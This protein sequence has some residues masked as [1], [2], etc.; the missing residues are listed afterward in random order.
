LSGESLMPRTIIPALLAAAAI[1]SAAAPSFAGE[2][3]AFSLYP[4][5]DAE[6]VAAGAS[7]LGVGKY[8]VSE[9]RAHDPLTLSRNDVPG[10][11]RI[12]LDLHSRRAGSMSDYTVRSCGFL[13][14]LVAGSPLLARD[15]DAFSEA[16]VNFAMY[17]ETMLLEQGMTELAKGVFRRSRPYAY[18]SSLSTETR[19]ERNAALSFWSGHTASAFACAMFAGYVYQER[20]P[21]SEYR[22]PIWIGGMSVAA[23]TAVLRVR[24]GQHFPTDVIAGAAAGSFAGWVVPCLHRARLSGVAVVTVVCGEPGL[25][26]HVAF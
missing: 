23:L 2:R 15:D 10:F 13:A 9:T 20:N 1:L 22:V 12:A 21:R 5:R 3:R 25:G 4:L 8:S 17:A 19:K 7:L 16:V 6:I 24:A 11:D 18:D 26:I 14:A